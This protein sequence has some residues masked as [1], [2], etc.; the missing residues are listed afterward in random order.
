[1]TEKPENPI[2]EQEEAKTMKDESKNDDNVFDGKSK[3][4][5]I[6]DYFN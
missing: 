2:K 6:F 1:M 5:E 4:Y 3:I